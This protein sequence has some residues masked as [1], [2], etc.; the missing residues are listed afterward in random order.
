[1]IP[2]FVMCDTEDVGAVTDT[3][4]LG[5]EALF[6]FDRYPGGMGYA[7]RCMERVEEILEASRVIVAS[8][9]CESGCPSCVGAPTPAFAMTDI[10]SAV[11]DRIP[12][13]AAA[14]LILTYLLGER[15]ED[16]E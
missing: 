1:V 15:G 4:C 13:K 6:V 14:A 9:S 16:H 8:C 2:M 3:R 12:D 5:A 10:D 11:R 7:R